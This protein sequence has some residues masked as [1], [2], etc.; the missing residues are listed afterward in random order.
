MSSIVLNNAWVELPVY[1]ADSKSLRT[2]ILNIA[3]AGKIRQ[4]SSKTFIVTALRDI[5]LD[6]KDGDRLALIGRNGAGKTSLLRLIAGIYEP[7]RG[8]V[9]CEGKVAPLLNISLGIDQDATGY[10]NIFL[11]GLYLGMERQETERITPSIEEFTELGEYLSMPVR[12]YSAGMLMRLAYAVAT[13]IQPDI[14][15]IDEV[16]GAGD[17]HFLVKARA[18]GQ[19]LI[20]S[21]NI[22]VF[23]SHDGGILKEFCNRAIL[24]EDGAVTLTGSVEEV[25]EAYQ[26]GDRGRSPVGSAHSITVSSRT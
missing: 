13:S 22:L 19:E 25:L 10:E 1:G 20:H 9:R 14:L 11:A 17:A 5:S 24:L 23:A 26:D 21:S 7:T 16:I 12:S 2:R 8:E 15:L 18:R 3:S 6:L 4:R